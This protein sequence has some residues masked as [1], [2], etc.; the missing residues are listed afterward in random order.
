M[1]TQIT[2]L[3]IVEP[4]TAQLVA[5]AGKTG[6]AETA[7]GSLVEAFKPH[8]IAARKALA[9]AEGVAASVKDATCLTEIRKSR[10]CRLA[11]R[12]IRIES[13]KTRKS[14][15]EQALVFGRAV[16]GFHNILLADLAPTEAALQAA[17]DTAERAETARLDAREQGR[18]AALAPFVANSALFPLRDMTEPAFVELLG[19]M[20]AAKEASDAAAAKAKADAEAKRIADAAEAERIRA[21]NARLKKEADDLKAEQDRIQAKA[22]ADAAAAKAE[23]DRIQKIADDAAQKAKDDAAAAQKLAD[24]KLAKERA[25]AKAE[26]DRLKAIS[27]AEKAAEKKKSDDALADQ[28]KESDR[29]AKIEHDR[30]AAAEKTAKDLRDA[31]TARLAAEKKKKDEEAAAAKKAAAAPDREKLLAYAATIL[32]LPKPGVVA[33]VGANR[34]LD[35]AIMELRATASNLQRTAANL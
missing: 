35:E 3:E 6:L 24:D 17:E 27:D 11:I 31:E 33:S 10:A 4:V 32:A 2:K 16:D 20:K 14:Q 30:V 19:G 9:D 7:T 26:Q 34:A 8:F 1:E 29:L 18:K 28:K 15:K 13:D 21:D 12:S 5:Y 25:A 23:Q 22:D